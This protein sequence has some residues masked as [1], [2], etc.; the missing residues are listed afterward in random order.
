MSTCPDDTLLQRYLAGACDIEESAA[1]AVHIDDCPRC[2]ERIEAAMPPEAAADTPSLDVRGESG[3]R[4]AK[5]APAPLDEQGAIPLAPIAPA[6]LWQPNTTDAPPASTG[7]SPSAGASSGSAAPP[8]VR[9]PSPGVGSITTAA[10]PAPPLIGDYEVV[11]K[12]SQGAQAVVYLAKHRPTGK[13]VAL[14]VLPR[15]MAANE[16]YLRRFRREAQAAASLEHPCIVRVHDHGY[17]NRLHYIAMEFIDGRTLTQVLDDGTPLS[18]LQVVQ[19]GAAVARGLE[20]AHARGVLHRDVKPG[21]I[22]LTPRGEVK[23]TDFGLAKWE[24]TTVS[25]QTTEGNVLGTPAYISPEQAVGRNDIDARAD[26]YSLGCVLFHMSAGRPPFLGE[27]AFAILDQHRRTEAPAVKLFNP[28][29]SDAL[30]A[31]VRR[32]M[33]K[34]REH[35]YQNAASMAADL[36]AIGGALA[37]TETIH[38]GLWQIVA[39]LDRIKLI[40]RMIGSAQGTTQTANW[41]MRLT[42]AF[43]QRPMVWFGAFAAGAAGLAAAAFYLGIR[44]GMNR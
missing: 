18:E 6:G 5:A 44:F 13:A 30:D 15:H 19:I 9:A 42:A 41:K 43:L 32:A 4:I 27:N 3:S 1:L 33:A 39:A 11:R 10:S 17:A 35:R 8:A 23:L 12:I 24:E 2:C 22:M 21:N 7:D 29:A 31:L 20:H 36:E 16:D 14:K 25:F 37:A 34:I 38:G 26:L 40:A 28:A